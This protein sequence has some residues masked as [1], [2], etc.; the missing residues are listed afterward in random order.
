MIKICI[1][2]NQPVVLQ[3]LTSYFSKHD[4]ISI[5]NQV[6]DFD[7]L[8]VVLKE[9][10]ID[11]VV[12]DLDL[13][14]LSKIVDLKNAINLFF[15]TK[16]IAFSTLSEKVFTANVLK[17]GV[18]GFVSKAAKMQSLERAILD[19]VGG[20]IVLDK[21]VKEKLDFFETQS[22]SDR[23]YRKISTREVEVLRYLAAGKKN[24]EV[25]KILNLDEKTISTYKLR[26]LAKLKVTNLVDL[27]NKAKMFDII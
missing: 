1:A 9:Y 10:K 22:K 18:R 16:F 17:A 4:K 23:L 26:L 15:D 6:S 8:V 7:S 13:E 19:V 11:A 12:F 20:E 5:V 27:I 25:A 2:D 21:K 24:K 14:G 3:G